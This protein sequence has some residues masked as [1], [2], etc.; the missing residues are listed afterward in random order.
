MVASPPGTFFFGTRLMAGF[1]GLNTEPPLLLL[2]LK[3]FWTWGL[4]LPFERSSLLIRRSLM[5]HWMPLVAL[6]TFPL[7]PLFS[8]ASTCF[9]GIWH[10][11]GLKPHMI[12]ECSHLLWISPQLVV[13]GGCWVPSVAIL[14]AGVEVVV[15]PWHG[16]H[17]QHISASL[18]DCSNAVYVSG[19]W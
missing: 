6:A 5:I 2:M 19:D 17:A 10:H 15:A 12:W 14:A 1:G 11:L 13:I 4:S 8:T 7:V 18:E 3:G 16:H 9:T